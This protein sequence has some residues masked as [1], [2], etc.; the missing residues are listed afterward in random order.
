[1]HR[2]HLAQGRGGGRAVVP[3]N[4]VI[5]TLGSRTLVQEVASRFLKILTR[6][7][8]IPYYWVFGL[9]PSSDILKKLENTMFRKQVLFPSTG[10]GGSYLLCC[11]P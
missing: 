6:V 1:M 3:V 7:Y 11:V 5:K 9:Y 2:I 4:M 10:E 8:N